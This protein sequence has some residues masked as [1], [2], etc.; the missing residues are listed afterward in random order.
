[1]DWNAIL[2]QLPVYTPVVLLILILFVLLI[3]LRTGR[4]LSIWP[5]KIG[6]SVEIARLQEQLKVNEER[7]SLAREENIGLEKKL[8]EII[9]ER[10]NLA[11]QINDL[12]LENEK[13]SNEIR[14]FSDP[15]L[16]SLLSLFDRM[17]MQVPSHDEDFAMMLRSLH[18]L[19]LDLQK[20]GIS[21][22][23]NRYLN[24]V[25]GAIHNDLYTIETMIRTFVRSDM[26]R[27]TKIFDPLMS[28]RIMRE[29]VEDSGDPR[30]DPL[31]IL[32][33]GA[34]HGAQLRI[35][36]TRRLIESMTYHSWRDENMKTITQDQLVSAMTF[37]WLLGSV[38]AL[39][40]G[41]MSQITIFKF[42]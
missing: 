16:R 8:A 22:I 28:Q 42:F 15:E 30:D 32:N 21:T 33:S 37:S 5:P 40:A 36:D 11:V 24:T 23:K 19:R 6:P 35:Q 14:V 38:D 3:I 10:D 25:F 7:L 41:I 20:Q 27:A 18:E 4:E 12:K 1:M 9:K 13:H 17:S 34:G 2:S 31:G 26:T 29:I 39:R